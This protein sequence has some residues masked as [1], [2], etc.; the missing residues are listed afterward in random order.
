MADVKKG[1]TLIE[2]LVVIAILAVL[3]VAVVL[4]LNPAELLKQGRDSNRLSDMATFN[5]ALSLYYTDVLG[6]DPSQWPTVGAS[7]VTWCT[8]LISSANGWS[9]W[10][11]CGNVA[12]TTGVNSTSAGWI[13]INFTLISSGSPISKLPVDPNNNIASCHG[14]AGVTNALCA[15]AFVASSTPGIYKVEALMESNKFSNGGSSAVTTGDGGVSSS[16]YEIGSN[17]T[18]VNY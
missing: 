5:S 4:V 17:L 2:L 7:P 9:N 3:A 10:G 12:T 11:A 13:P 18:F 1:F 16:T 6:A 15:Y 8:A 14:V